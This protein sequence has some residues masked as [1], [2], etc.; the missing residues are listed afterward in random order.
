M[1]D[2]LR[3]S[4]VSISE[5]AS[6]VSVFGALAAGA[7]AAVTALAV[8]DGVPKWLTAAVGVVAAISTAVFGFLTKQ[9]VTARTTPWTDVAAKVT[10][11]GKVI[12]GPAA[13]QPTGTTVAVVQDTPPAAFEPGGTV[14]PTPEGD[15]L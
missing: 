2:P 3:S 10:P 11:T 12:A 7:T 1:S 8:I 6:L 4:Q 13:E 15:P 14:Y 9:S 5:P